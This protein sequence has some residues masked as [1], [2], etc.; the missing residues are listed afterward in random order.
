VQIKLICPSK[1]IGD[2]SSAIHW[3]AN[4]KVVSDDRIIF[5]FG[6]LADVVSLLIKLRL[7][8]WRVY[9]G[10]LLHESPSICGIGSIAFEGPASAVVDILFDPYRQSDITAKSSSLRGREKRSAKMK[11]GS[12]E[13]LPS[14][15]TWQATSA[16]C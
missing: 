1:C 6:I 13:D 16:R 9:G 4:P 10:V 11:S 14:I 8:T 3:K 2:V 5:G 15:Q 7:D 12:R